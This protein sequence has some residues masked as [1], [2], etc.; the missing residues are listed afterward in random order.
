M[1]LILLLICS[2]L[3][4]V[5]VPMVKLVTNELVPQAQG[6]LALASVQQT[7]EASPTA[8]PADQCMQLEADDCIARLEAGMGAIMAAIATLQ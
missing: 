2:P 3:S 8:P 6:A 1:C 4:N 5:I 7:Q